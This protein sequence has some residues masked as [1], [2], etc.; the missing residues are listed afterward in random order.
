VEKERKA[1]HQISERRI[2]EGGRKKQKEGEEGEMGKPSKN[3][4][5]STNNNM[6]EGH[7]AIIYIEHKSTASAKR[8][9]KQTPAKSPKRLCFPHP[10]CTFVVILFM[11]VVQLLWRFLC[12]TC[13]L[14]FFCS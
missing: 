14:A 6:K 4:L 5:P 3:T 12:F 9:R 1:E 8:R 11:C 2:Q 7:L 13:V 10:I